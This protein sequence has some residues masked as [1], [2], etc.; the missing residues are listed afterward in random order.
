MAQVALAVTNAKVLTD[1]VE[2]FASDQELKITLVSPPT[3]TR[4]V[5][6]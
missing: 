4:G 3:T 2:V 6:A 5:T 1:N